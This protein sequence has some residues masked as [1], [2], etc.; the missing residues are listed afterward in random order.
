MAPEPKRNRLPFEPKQAKKKPPKA[1]PA[2]TM[3]A[4]SEPQRRSPKD[5]ASLSMIPDVVS[6]RMI[7]RMA[8]FCGLPT[9]LGINSF[10][11]SYFIVANE[12]MEL[13]TIAVLLVSLGCFG[14]GVLGLSY[15]ILSTSWDENRVGSI[16]GWEEFQVNFGRM[17]QAWRTS[18]RESRSK[19]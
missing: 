13:P 15:G 12:L 5:D 14:L 6:K 11:I 10:V 18:R 8:L 17:V 3:T 2:P 19:S 9:A 1:A 16:L 4:A 7:R